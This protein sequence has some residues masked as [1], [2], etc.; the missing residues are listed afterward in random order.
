MSGLKEEQR[1]D[2]TGMIESMFESR[3]KN[4]L[5]NINYI[6]KN[7][8]YKIELS[9]DKESFTVNYDNSFAKLKPETFKLNSTEAYRWTQAILTGNMTSK[10]AHLRRLIEGPLKDLKKFQNHKSKP[11]PYYISLSID[12]LNNALKEIG[13]LEELRDLI[14]DHEP[15]QEQGPF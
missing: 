8:F 15:K 7:S 11:Q 5:R 13:E 2:Q 10:V 9:D 1:R 3:K 6:S 14:L 12:G 4:I